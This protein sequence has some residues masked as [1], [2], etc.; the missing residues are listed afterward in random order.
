MGIIRRRR[1]TSITRIN[2]HPD[3]VGVIRCKIRGEGGFKIFKITFIYNGQ[4]QPARCHDRHDLGLL[5]G[6]LM[7]VRLT[8][9][10]LIPCNVTH[11]HGHSWA[12]G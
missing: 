4:A 3:R 1:H 2:R 5:G 6:L 9:S 8:D 7:I 10:T 12:S 11:A